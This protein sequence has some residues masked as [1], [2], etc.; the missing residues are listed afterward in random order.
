MVVINHR[1]LPL[2]SIGL[3]ALQDTI[4]WVKFG[5][6]S[7]KFFHANVTISH[8]KN[9]ITSL[10]DDTTESR[11]VTLEMVA[12]AYEE[13]QP[14][15]EG[16]MDDLKLEVRKLNKHWERAVRD[17]APVL[18]GLCP[19]PESAS[20]RPPAGVTADGPNGHR[21]DIYNREDGYGSVTTLLYPPVKGTCLLPPPVPRNSFSSPHRQSG[22]RGSSVS[23]GGS[24]SG[25][26]PKL[27]FPVF[28]G[29][30][31]SFG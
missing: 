30:S 6:E 9:L 1:N 10:A 5:D 13:W 22:S 31:L 14:G 24:G 19:L 27:N 8:R 16:T 28:D 26:I 7:T 29:D 20:A 23:L 21:V 17:N 4:K 18:P 12:A 11:L 25:K 15:I 2:A 3:D